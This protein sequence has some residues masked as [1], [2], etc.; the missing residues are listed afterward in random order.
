VNIKGAES[1]MAKKATAGPKKS[2]DA[3]AFARAVNE[4]YKGNLVTKGSSNVVILNVPRFST[5]IL[6]VDEAVG[7]GWPRGRITVL[8]GENS[9]GKTEMVIQACVSVQK[10]DKNTKEHTL[11][12][13]H[14]ARTFVPSRALYIDVENS[15]DKVWAA[16]KG[17]DLGHHYIVRP[18]TS[19]QAIDIITRA[20]DEGHFDL[21]VLDSIAQMTPSAELEASSEDWQMGLAA[22]LN[23]KAFRKWVSVMSKKNRAGKPA[24]ALICINQMRLNIG[25]M[26][27]D[28]RSLPGGKGQEFA[29]SI[30]VYTRSSKYDNTSSAAASVVELGGVVYKNKTF[31]PKQ[32]YTFKMGVKQ[33]TDHDLGE[34]DNFTELL[35]RAKEVGFVKRAGGTHNLFKLGY[36]SES[37]L[38]AALKSDEALR[39]KLWRSI[40]K[41]STKA[42][43]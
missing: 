36:P 38:R 19:E 25:Q 26:F 5:G 6:S 13:D 7:G 34:V 41:H 21:I 15:F 37:S 8:A 42:E 9:T 1:N 24:P 35:K 27:G 12:F 22:R 10:Y 2:A 23:N 18:D 33:S 30:I 40:V 17:F 11:L 14:T 31:T 4:A 32:N 43:L 16:K 28:P 29:A 3:A 20:L 39:Y